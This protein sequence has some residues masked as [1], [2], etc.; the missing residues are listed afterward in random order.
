M[1]TK[2]HT[3]TGESTIEALKKAQEACGEKAILV[4]TKQIQAKTI[5]KKP[6]YEILVSVE[7]DDVKQPP[8]PNTKAI[9]YENAYS[10]FSKN[11]EPPKPKF[12]IKEEPAK[13]EVKTTSPE[14]YDPNES[15]LLNISAAAKE[16]ST[17]ANVN[18]DDVKDK[19]SSIPS[20]MNKKIDDVAKQ[21][22]VLSEKIGLITDMIWDE[23]AP[24]RNNLS[25]P[26]EFASIYKLAKQSGMKEEH[27]EAI[28]QT[29]LENLPVSMKSNPTA[30]KRYFYSLLRNMLPCRK[31]PSDKKQRIMM[32]VG[33]TGVGKTTTLA[34]LAARFA[35]GNEKRYKT[36]II[37]LDTY[38]IGAV[39]QLFQYAKMMKLP[40]L[41]VI[42]I[43]DFQ[44]AIK[45]L[46]YCDVI[47]IDTT[48]N[49][50]YDKEKLERLDKFLK[51]SGAKIDVNLVLSAGSKVEDL[52]EIY[53]G[54]SFL[55]I[56]TLIITKFDETKIFGNVFSLIYETNTPVSYFSVGQEVPDD[57]VEA[58]S[59]FL[60]ECVFD[61][62]TKQKASD[63]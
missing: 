29:T 24:N 39:E 59:E 31:E 25:I 19:E 43:D 61:G 35:Y 14:P 1:A 34:K 18:I 55:D 52:I 30:V 8:K 45:Q 53:N 17:I 36:G 42:E 23:K 9:N 33:P 15:V 5:N 10:K 20:G 38:R 47:L 22:S 44:N 37:T 56:D 12:E 51:H 58:K 48:G 50:Q 13:F 57:L 60:V 46:N 62:F 32:L 63:E 2:F 6:L 26:P 54:F 4:T 21:V 11:Y 40:I 3:F 7:E 27:L 49:S 16:I 28:M 41:D